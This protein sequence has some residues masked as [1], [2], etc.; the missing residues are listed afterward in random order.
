MKHFTLASPTLVIYS[1]F[2][3]TVAILI[4]LIICVLDNTAQ[5]LIMVVLL[6]LHMNFVCFLFFH[7]AFTIVTYSQ[8]GIKNKYLYLRYDDIQ[9]ATIIDVELFKYSIGRTIT[10]QMICLSTD[11]QKNS[12]WKCSKR[13]CILLPNTPKVLHRLKEYSGNR[14]SAICALNHGTA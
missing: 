5:T 9:H 1:I 11:K 10:I 2:A 6:H 13:G 3:P 4:P 12:F 14:S 7:R 8:C